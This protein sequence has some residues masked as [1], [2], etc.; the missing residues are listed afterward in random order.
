MLE[1]GGE[2]AVREVL[3]R[4][5]VEE[6]G[7]VSLGEGEHGI[8]HVVDVE[9]W[10]A[11]VE[12]FVGKVLVAIASFFQSTFAKPRTIGGVVKRAHE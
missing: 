2:D 11:K 4:W 6:R 9:T 12:G 5:R 10:E 1:K 3:Q 7:G 8:G